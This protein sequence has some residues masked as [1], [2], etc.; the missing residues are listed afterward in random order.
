MPQVK[1][2]SAR[3]PLAFARRSAAIVTAIALGVGGMLVAPA[4]AQAATIEGLEGEGTPASPLILDSPQ[5]LDLAAAA[6]NSDFATYGSLSFRLDR[7]IDYR[8]ATFATFAKFAGEFD[9]NGHTIS[10]VTYAAPAVGTEQHSAFFRELNGATV[11]GLTLDGVRAVVTAAAPGVSTLVEVSGF[12][13]NAIDST[14]NGN[15]VRNARVSGPDVGNGYNSGFISRAVGSTVSNNMIAGAMQTTG[16]KY[17]SAFLGYLGAGSTVEKNLV[18]ADPDTSYTVRNTAGGDNNT[19]GML[20]AYVGADGADQ[21]IQNNAIVSGSVYSHATGAFSNLGWIAA[22]NATEVEYSG[23]NLV[24]E[25]NNRVG[26]PTV[27]ETPITDQPLRWTRRPGDAYAH[28]AMSGGGLLWRLGDDGTLTSNAALRDQATYETLGWDFTDTWR[29]DEAADHPVVQDAPKL[30]V[31]RTN[32]SVAINTT[33]NEAE[34]LAALGAQH[35]RG[36]LVVDL[37]AVTFTEAGVY[38]VTVTVTE[39]RFTHAIAVT[40]TVT[41]LPVAQVERTTATYQAGSAPSVAR[42]LEDLG[43][44][45]DR[46]ELA[47]DLTGVD[48]S[49]TGDYPA[50][51]T[52]TDEGN[53]SNSIAV[54]ISIVPL[55][56]AGTATSPFLIGTAADLDAAS[57]MVNAD[58][59]GTRAAAAQY[60]VTQDIDY[61]GKTFARFG[62]F[63]GTFLGAGHAIRNL[64]VTSTGATAAGVFTELNGATVTGL[65]LENVHVT[66]SLGTSRAAVLTGL[67][68]NARIQ[69][70]T[71]L[72][73]TVTLDFATGSNNG[74]AAVIAGASTLGTI[75][76]DNVVM[77]TEVLGAKYAAGLV[78]YPNNNQSNVVDNNLLVDVT[79]AARATGGGSSVGLLTSQGGTGTRVSGN[80][81]I[82]G[83]IGAANAAVE[84]INV[85]PGEV[86][87]PVPNY[88]SAETPI[89]QKGSRGPNAT[90]VA[91]LPAGAEAPFYTS[92][93][94]DLASPEALWEWEPKLGHP[95]LVAA[96]L[97]G[98]AVSIDLAGGTDGGANVTTHGYGAATAL[99][100][101]TR[102]HYAFA[103]WIGS[104]L[105]GSVTDVTLPRYPSG[106]LGY[107][108]TWQATE[109]TIAYDLAGGTGGG[110]MLTYSIETGEFSLAAPT[111]AGYR[112][113]GWTGTDLADQTVDVVIPAGAHG[114]RSYTAHWSPLP[115]AITYDLAGGQAA[116]AGVT[117]YTV[118]SDAFALVNPTRAGYDFAGWVGTGLTEPTTSVTV[119]RGS[120]G[121]RDYTATW[122]PKPYHVIYELGD[123]E[124]FDAHPVGEYTIESP[125]F[126]LPTP[127]RRGHEFAG[128]I[129][130]DLEQPTMDVIVPQGSTGERS[131]RPT[132]AL[133]QYTIRYS[134]GGGR[135]AT[136]NPVSYTTE[137]PAFTLTKPTR[138]DYTFAGWRGLGSTSTSLTVQPGTVGNLHFTATW[139]KKART[140]PRISASY[141][142]KAKGQRNYARV[143]VAV[144]T[145]TGYSRASGNV[146]VTV[147]GKIRKTVN[148]TR[149]TVKVTRHAMGT[150][151]N[152]RATVSLPKKLGAGNY[153]LTVKY[154]GNAMYQSGT[155]KAYSLK[156][157]GK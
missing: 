105:I 31:E 34:V 58:T 33:M 96:T 89:T 6:V 8:G 90:Q 2:D 114:N 146:R 113:L 84:N 106:D 144:A 95:I 155:S 28:T 42:I 12:A 77:N 3:N 115:Y 45:T 1:R 137:S 72:G 121:A 78:A 54:T 141:V 62:T 98:V 99:V 109:F 53:T 148:G 134:L 41:Q 65:T 100:A 67:A 40:I 131:Y 80:V 52:A 61:A 21:V 139:K 69:G 27:A 51:V 63:R 66:N 156:I 79:V 112:F 136:A 73:S 10:D 57:A 132:W 149:T 97:P 23:A 154:F 123:G 126:T 145:K 26:F 19:A 13:R 116:S 60:R 76:S 4:T 32:L 129:G 22:V 44:T 82:R 151:K 9:G 152:G 103:G 150:M 143:N 47:I 94:W 71:V 18:A 55:A 35:D 46:G 119:P 147:T 110:A 16:D 101:P 5:D 49:T 68:T 111:R 43:A 127:V 128:W 24:N 29:W 14:V 7:D 107:T 64:K 157:K 38:P 108:A 125:A 59:A 87:A 75:I 83:G 133:A 50:T 70:N 93:G 15:V 135:V 39:G 117:E 17:A 91:E 92:L 130:T 81:I 124:E 88:V 86:S 56:G 104:G 30:T 36:D 20:V 102:E 74:Q 140:A 120:T 48:F 142:P 25:S 118:E 153:R 138:T 85:V 11:H 122:A 37:S